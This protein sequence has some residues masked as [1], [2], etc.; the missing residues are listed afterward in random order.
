VLIKF[1]H[2]AAIVFGMDIVPDLFAL[3]AKYL[4]LPAFE[5]ALDQIAERDPCNSTPLRLGLVRHPPRR[6]QVG[7]LKYCPYS[8]T[9]TS[10]A[11]LD[12]PTENALID[13]S[14]TF[15]ESR[16]RRRDRHKGTS[17]LRRP[18]GCAAGAEGGL[19]SRSFP[20][21]RVFFWGRFPRGLDSGIAG[22]Q[23][24][25]RRA[26]LLSMIIQRISKGGSVAS[27]SVRCG[28]SG[29]RTILRRRLIQHKPT[30]CRVP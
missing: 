18:S 2:E 10:A 23:P 7:I 16:F 15:P 17:T 8:C 24:K 1:I 27:D 5:I 30:A 20:A 6:Q 13:R 3:I 26:W 14:Q 25:S 11:T 28:R 22:I 4:V 21:S 29:H 9:T 19:T 12:A